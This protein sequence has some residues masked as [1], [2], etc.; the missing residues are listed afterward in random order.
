[1]ELLELS[2]AVR[3]LYGSLGFKGVMH[4]LRENYL[5]IN[6]KYFDKRLINSKYFYYG[7]LKMA[8]CGQNTLYI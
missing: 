7:Y 6:M 2:G 1:M 4:L 5:F 8:P 3:P